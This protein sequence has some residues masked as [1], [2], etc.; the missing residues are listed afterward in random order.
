M[1]DI[2]NG[3]LGINIQDPPLEKESY[4]NYHALFGDKESPDEWQD[5][6]YQRYIPREPLTPDLTTFTFALDATPSN[7][8]T[9]LQNIQ[10]NL[11]VSVQKLDLTK[12][13]WENATLTDN[14]APIS[15]LLNGIWDDI[16]IRCN[17]T[18]LTN[19]HHNFTALNFIMTR[20]SSSE[21]S[22]RT[23]LVPEGVIADE[24]D[25][26]D[27]SV[28]N[29]GFTDRCALYTKK[30]KNEENLVHLVGDLNHDLKTLEGP[31]PSNTS[32][33]IRLSK[34]K[35]EKVLMVN[36][37][38]SDDSGEDDPEKLKQKY[39]IVIKDIELHI[40][41]YIKIKYF[42]YVIFYKPMYNCRIILKP[43]L[44]AKIEKLMETRPLRYF[45]TRLEVNIYYK[46]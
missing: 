12:Q 36:M 29:T 4:L 19:R 17:Q 30:D 41:R 31:F 46:L 26:D 3:A 9:N 2:D 42:K 5:Y 32:I 25:P 28:K 44:Q 34:A 11:G 33:I 1:T 18:S 13:I 8:W 38:K 6:H 45:Y 35:D 24:N 37:K 22:R 27:T 14:C 43:E 20:L 10:L 15:G 23:Y 21:T 40:K 39:R 16:D 7:I